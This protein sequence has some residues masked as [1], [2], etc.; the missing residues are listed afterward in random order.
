MTKLH[1]NRCH[2]MTVISTTPYLTSDTS[3]RQYHTP[4]A[5]ETKCREKHENNNGEQYKQF[6]STWEMQEQ[7]DSS[8]AKF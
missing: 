3:Q 8:L 4:R 5:A 1:N 6:R 7:Q 2:I